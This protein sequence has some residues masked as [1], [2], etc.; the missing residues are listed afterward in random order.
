MANMIYPA[1]AETGLIIARDV[2]NGNSKNLPIPYLPVPAQLMA[3]IVVYGTLAVL[4]DRFDTIAALLGWG[5][6]TATALNLYS[7]RSKVKTTNT[8][9]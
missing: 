8:T 6:V 5:F 1:I 3:V 9:S 7:P 2:M 4:P